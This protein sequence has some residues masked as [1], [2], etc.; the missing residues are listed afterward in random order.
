MS[1]SFFCPTAIKNYRKKPRQLNNVLIFEYRSTLKKFVTMRSLPVL[2]MMA[3]IISGCNKTYTY[4]ETVQEKSLFGDSDNLRVKKAVTIGARNDT[5]AYRKAYRKYYTSLRICS[6]IAEKD[7][8]LV[9]IPIKF[10]LYGPKGNQVLPYLDVSML[11]CITDHIMASEKD[12]NKPLSRAK[13]AKQN[14]VDSVKIKEVSALFSFNR[15][16]F[17]PRGLTWIK[18]KSAPQYTN[19]NAIYCYFMKDADEVV[20]NFRLRIQYCADNGLFIRKYQFSIDGKAYEFV[21]DK[22]E[23][24]YSGGRVWEWCDESPASEQNIAIVKALAVAG[25]AKIKFIGRQYSDTRAL[26]QK[27]IKGIK[28]AFDLYIAMGGSL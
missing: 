26:S 27:E 7:S 12:I 11:D 21:P 13:R 25:N 28:N 8:R 5:L 17:D 24:D 4:M 3:V 22:V 14:P 6:A 10:S 9:G 23:H 16:E 1:V 20:S 19:R 18:P 15:D 2:L